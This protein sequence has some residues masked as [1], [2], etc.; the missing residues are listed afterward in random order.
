MKG[1]ARNLMSPRVTKVVTDTPVA[2]IA[3]LLAVGGIGGVPVVDANERVV[4]FV[5]EVDIMDALLA[6]RP[7]HATASALMTAP[8]ITVDEFDRTEDVMRLL[9]HH[10]IHHLPV[11]REG[12]LVGIIT[13]ADV[14]RFLVKELLS[15]PPEVS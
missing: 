3:Q 4:G 1:H 11:V 7:T 15:I 9:R 13:P 10:R 12:R 5:S 8:A 14:I 6:G 2:D